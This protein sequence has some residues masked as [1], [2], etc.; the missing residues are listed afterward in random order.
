MS[1]K[2]KERANRQWQLLIKAI[3][4][5]GLGEH[6]LTRFPEAL[7][8]HLMQHC[9]FIAHYN[10]RGFFDTYFL[11]G[12][13][14]RIFLQHFD[15]RHSYFSMQCY[16]GYADYKDLAEAMLEFVKPRLPALYQQAN[17]ADRTRELSLA[18]L[19]AQKHGRQP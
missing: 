8:H 12:S 10:R 18:Q 19:L 5:E 3:E 6:L 11:R 15:S 13:D 4:K 17:G 2:E 16:G 1:A 9:G 14:L 7:Y